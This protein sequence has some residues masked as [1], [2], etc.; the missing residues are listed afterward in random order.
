MQI[1]RFVNKLKMLS[2]NYGVDK[3][4]TILLLLCFK[5]EARSSAV[6]ENEA[7]NAKCSH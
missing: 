3:G 4:P 5:N 1:N 6:T 7:L 2:N